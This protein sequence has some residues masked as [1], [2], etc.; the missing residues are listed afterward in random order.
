MKTDNDPVTRADLLAVLEGRCP[1]CEEKVGTWRRISENTN[2]AAAHSFRARGIDPD[3]GHQL[4]CGRVKVVRPLP[5]GLCDFCNAVG[6]TKRIKWVAG[7]LSPRPDK[8]NRKDGVIYSVCAKC[9]ESE[10]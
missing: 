7:V 4:E 9:E 6:P 1:Y 10:S 3:T 8:A 2:A 5:A